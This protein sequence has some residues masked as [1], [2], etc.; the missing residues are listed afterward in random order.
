[1]ASLKCSA[2]KLSDLFRT[3]RK[4]E[5]IALVTDDIQS[6]ETIKEQ[7]SDKISVDILEIDVLP[8]THTY[9]A[10]VFDINLDIDRIINYM[11]SREKKTLYGF[12][13]K[14]ERI[15]FVYE[16]NKCRTIYDNIKV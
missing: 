7:L 15:A 8:D 9:D 3:E 12:C 13:S 5:R 16:G 10:I 14:T 4:I 1:M 6:T 2:L 11:K